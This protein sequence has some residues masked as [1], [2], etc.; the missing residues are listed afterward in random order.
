MVYG[1][2]LENRCRAT[3]RGFKSHPLRH[4]FIFYLFITKYGLIEVIV[5]KPL[6]ASD[7]ITPSELH[8]L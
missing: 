1:A 6:F 4:Y 5:S 3:Y 7:S 8:D 2:G